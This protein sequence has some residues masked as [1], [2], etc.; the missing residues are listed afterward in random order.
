MHARS[1]IRQDLYHGMRLAKA[2]TRGGFDRG[3]AC[4]A[5]RLS[6]AP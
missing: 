1:F 5:T 6:E 2:D 4:K 3:E